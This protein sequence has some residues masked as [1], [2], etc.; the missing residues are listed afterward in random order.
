MV[1]KGATAWD[2]LTWM[3]HFKRAESRMAVIAEVKRR[4]PALGVLSERVDPA[5]QARAY[6]AA[7]P[8]SPG[9]IRPSR[10][11]PPRSSQVRVGALGL[12]SSSPSSPCTTSA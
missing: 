10:T 6:A 7:R 4:S 8:N 12:I 3:L 5:E 11:S 9:S 1:E 2:P